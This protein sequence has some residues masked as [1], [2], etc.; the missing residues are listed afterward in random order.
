MISPTLYRSS[1]IFDALMML[2]NSHAFD[3]FADEIKPFILPFFFSANLMVNIREVVE[4][5]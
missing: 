1:S 5:Q 3:A 2:G 4:F